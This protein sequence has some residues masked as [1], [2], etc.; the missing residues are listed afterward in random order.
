M[1]GK[2]QAQRAGDGHCAVG[3]PAG[4]PAGTTSTRSPG[5]WRK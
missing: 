2:D 3:Y 1:D 5:T 4:E